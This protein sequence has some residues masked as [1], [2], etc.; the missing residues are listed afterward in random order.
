M[1]EVNC[2]NVCMVC[3]SALFV[4]ALTSAQTQ[5]TIAMAICTAIVIA[6]VVIVLI[7]MILRWQCKQIY[8]IHI[9]LLPWNSEL[10][11]A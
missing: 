2:F 9:Y 7:I 11:D 8:V 5:R 6:L 4:A 10:R 3:L 1:N